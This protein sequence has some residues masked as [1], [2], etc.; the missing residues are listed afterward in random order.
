MAPEGL[1]TPVA[2][3]GAFCRQGAALFD[4]TAKKR[5]TPGPLSARDTA[6]SLTRKLDVSRCSPQTK[7][8]CPYGLMVLPM[9]G[10]RRIISS[11]MWRNLASKSATA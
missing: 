4:L 3:L 10:C 8:P 9:H 6:A 2:I 1:D 7:K 5:P 11:A